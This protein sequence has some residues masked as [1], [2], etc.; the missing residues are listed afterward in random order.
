VF[1]LSKC[2][3][4]RGIL[5]VCVC[6]CYENFYETFVSKRARRGEDFLTLVIDRKK[7]VIQVHQ[8]LLQLQ[9]L[10][11][12]R[13]TQLSG[14]PPERKSGTGEPEPGLSRRARLSD[15]SLLQ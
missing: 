13:R 4:L 10:A 5:C 1:N 11:A 6:V 9:S 8:K 3:I 2:Q 12:T 15:V 7:K 14:P